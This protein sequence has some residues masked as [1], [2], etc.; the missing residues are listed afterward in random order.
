MSVGLVQV[1]GPLGIAI[2]HFEFPEMRVQELG[3]EGVSRNRGY[4]Q[5][6][7]EEGARGDSTVT[8]DTGFQHDVGVLGTCA[9]CSPDEALKE[10]RD[11]AGVV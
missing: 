2:W 11:G 5:E 4:G 6:S 9:P 3:V 8:F 10:H 1:R 7:V